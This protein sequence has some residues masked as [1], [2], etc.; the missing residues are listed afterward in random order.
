MKYITLF[1]CFLLLS[2]SLHAYELRFTWNYPDDETRHEGFKLYYSNELVSENLIAEFDNPDAR[3]YEMDVDDLHHGA[4]T[5]KLTAY[6]ATEESDPATAIFTPEVIKSGST[7]S[8][9][10]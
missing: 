4:N 3:W 5:F 1:I 6:N 8:I 2:A 7:I 10:F 9:S